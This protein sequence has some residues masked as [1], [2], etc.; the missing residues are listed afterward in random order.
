[1]PVP[2]SVLIPVGDPARELTRRGVLAMLL[3]AAGFV[4]FAYVTSHIAAVR[5][6]TPWQDDPYDVVVSFTLFFVPLAAGLMLLR[7]PLCRRAQPLPASRLSGIQRAGTIV[8][9]SIGATLVADWSAVAVGAQRASWTGV[10]TLAVDALG[11]LTLVLVG[12]VVMHA[13][14]VM[15]FRH[16]GSPEAGPDWLDD[17]VA[18]FVLTSARIHPRFGAAAAQGSAL[19]IEGR[20]GVR[21][22]PVATTL[23]ASLLF[24]LALS[25]GEIIG[26][27]GSSSAATAIRTFILYG[28]IGG[29]GMAAFLTVAGRYLHLLRAEQPRPASRWPIF[30]TS[31]TVAAA[32]IPM[33]VAFRDQISASTTGVLHADNFEELLGLVIL[34]A[35]VAAVTTLA[36]SAAIRAAARLGV[37]GKQ[38]RGR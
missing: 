26:G 7:V 6:V 35:I 30:G 36:L 29:A 34:I 37:G 31:L 18:L 16:Q 14:A 12:A 28:L 22:H 33:T 2:A 38:P 23:G 9:I 5:D 21:R 11:L 17:A 32:S 27:G 24:G 3:A 19:V 15:S 8:A 13:R 25:L 4:F 10:T 20:H 1:M